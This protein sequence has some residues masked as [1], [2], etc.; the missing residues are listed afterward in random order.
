M[1]RQLNRRC[2]SCLD[3]VSMAAGMRMYYV[4]PHPPIGVLFLDRLLHKPYK[5]CLPKFVIEVLSSRLAAA[6]PMLKDLVYS[7][8]VVRIRSR[9]CIMI[10]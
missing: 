3:A 5:L 9:A 1:F 2:S 10:V 6:R 8:F 7:E 4:T